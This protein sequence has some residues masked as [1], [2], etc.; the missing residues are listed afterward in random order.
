MVGGRQGQAVLQATRI[1]T[2]EH[3]VRFYFFLSPSHFFHFG[4]EL[5]DDTKPIKIRRQQP[6]KKQPKHMTQRRSS[7]A[8]QMLLPTLSSADMMWKLSQ[9]PSYR[10]EHQLNE[11][12]SPSNLTKIN[13][14]LTNQTKDS[15]STLCQQLSS[16]TLCSFMVL[17]ASRLVCPTAVSQRMTS[18][19]AIKTIISWRP[20]INTKTN[21]TISKIWGVASSN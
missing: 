18:M 9:T 12:N 1:F 15:I 3:L 21:I 14:L 5:D 20:K 6:R 10:S 19:N 17:L 8:V 16:T 2:S 4:P 7:F 11:S 13:S